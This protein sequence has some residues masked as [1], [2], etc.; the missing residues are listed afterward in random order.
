MT[1]PRNLALE[2]VNGK[3]YLT[4]TPVPELKNI[5]GKETVLTHVQAADVRLDESLGRL[6]GPSELELSGDQ[7]ESFTLE[8]S[9]ESGDKLLIG[10]D[11]EANQYFIDR[12][13]SGKVNFHRDFAKRHSAPRLS[14]GKNWNL[15]LVIDDAS[16]ELFADDGLSVMTE[17]FFPNHAFTGLRIQSPQNNF[18]IKSV[19]YHPLKSIWR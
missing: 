14:S 3:Y 2:K 9:N 12:S 5:Y 7:L 17:I 11:K 19:I 10:Y 15:K 1:I 16:V 4:S 8:L 18:V 6:S 13:N